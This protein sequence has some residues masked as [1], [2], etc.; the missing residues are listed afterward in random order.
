MRI[1]KLSWLAGLMVIIIATGG[2]SCTKKYVN[3]PVADS[4]YL[5]RL[6]FVLD[7][8]PTYTNF[9]AAL[10]QTGWLDTLSEPGPFT[11]LLPNNDAYNQG[12]G[13]SGTLD[14][15]IAQEVTVAAPLSA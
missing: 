10:Q 11:V 4:L 3:D 12:Y 13:A 8:N 6:S 2:S 15:F 14:Q 1:G 7:N 5:D 9:Y